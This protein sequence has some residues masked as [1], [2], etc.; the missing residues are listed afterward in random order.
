MIAFANHPPVNLDA[1]KF[2]VKLGDR[3]L[4]PFRDFPAWAALTNYLGA[5][6]GEPGK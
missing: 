3:R 5:L 2:T 1:T 4:P 6:L